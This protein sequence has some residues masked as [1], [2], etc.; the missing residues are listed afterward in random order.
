MLWGPPGTGK[1]RLARAAAEAAK[2]NL[3]VVNGPEIIG[4]YVGQSEA[5]LR[6]VFQAA[7]K[8]KPCVILLD[9]L[10]AI[11][12]RAERQRRRRREG[13]RKQRRRG[14][15]VRARRLHV[16]DHHGRRAV[17]GG[18]FC[19]NVYHPPLGFN[20]RS[21]GVRPFQLTDE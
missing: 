7:A 8:Q 1:T 12:P 2:A 15:D 14:P 20:I 16:A 3:L 5:A 17:G 6:G 11:A 18:A 4:A 10:D 19:A 21:R 9:E 13:R